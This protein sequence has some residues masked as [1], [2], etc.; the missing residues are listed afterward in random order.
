MEQ[1]LLEILANKMRVDVVLFFSFQAYDRSVYF[2]LGQR[3]SVVS[4]CQLLK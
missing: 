2:I 1:V 4:I 3:L